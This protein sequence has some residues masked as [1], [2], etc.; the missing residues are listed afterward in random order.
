[1]SPGDGL[2]SNLTAV[3]SDFDGTLTTSGRFLAS[4]HA[5][6]E[7]LEAAGVD[8]VI[9]TGRPSGWA[10]VFARTLPVR[11]VVAENGGVVV[12]PKA[13][14]RGL[15]RIYG[16]N[17][18]ELPLLRRKMLAA[19]RAVI[20]QVPG[21]RLAS[22]VTFT[23]VNLAIDWNED[24]KLPEEAARRV[25][26]LLRERGYRAVRSSVHVNF[27]PGRFDKLTACR[28]VVR[29]VLGGSARDLSPYLY[30]GDAL[31]DEPMFRGFPRSVGVANIK[32]V[33]E[34]LEHKPAH[35][36][37]AAEG[38]GFEELAA[39]ILAYQRRGK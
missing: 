21:A 31:N 13:G 18:R 36:T 15:R 5:A 3:F 17:L 7:Q 26:K 39:A 9:V 10:D 32:Q 33:W 37:R 34:E 16:V 20:R 35:V 12:V 23:E 14:G 30:V 29:E 38:R 24:V 27:W 4:T 25:E 6:L 8:V 2:F 28:R 19:A 11:A 22:D 1:M